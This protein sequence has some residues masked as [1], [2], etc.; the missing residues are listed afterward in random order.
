MS[1]I[2]SD[3]AFKQFAESENKQSNDIARGV[4]HFEKEYEDFGY[5]ALELNKNKPFRFLG[6]VPNSNIDNYTAR[7]VCIAKIVD[8]TG[9]MMKVIRPLDDSSNII[10]RIIKFVNTP[11]YVKN[12]TTGKVDKFYAMERDN[13][14]I[15]NIVNKNGFTSEQPRGKFDKGWIGKT[16]LVANV[17]DR[18]QMDWHRANKHTVMLA[19]SISTDDNG[20]DWADEGIS[21]FASL[22]LFKE[23]F[24]YYGNWEK[25]DIGI[26]RTGQQTPA[27]NI[28]NASKNPEM[29]ADEYREFVSTE[30]LTDEELSWDRYDFSVIYRPTNCIKIYN[31]LKE[32]IGRIDKECGTH[33]LADLEKDVVVERERLK[34]I[35]KNEEVSEISEST[36]TPT[37]TQTSEV[38]SRTRSTTPTTSTNTEVWKQL[39]FADKLPE[40]YR[41]SVKAVKK[42]KD[43]QVVSVEWDI[44]EEHLLEC[45]DCHTSGPEDL[46]ECPVCGATF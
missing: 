13:F 27:F 2:I 11:T 36:S 16:V 25:Y 23:L 29:I 10:N 15:F 6:G 40:K 9:K 21:E 5:G 1:E 4:G 28:I 22:S 34:E 24:K 43:G 31:R 33:F 17:I 26:S 20:H 8:D 30:P 14:E 46:T 12:E 38:K 18:T 37:V 19:K 3:D 44:D 35:Y 45:T 39:P 41:N 42:N 7:T 32:T